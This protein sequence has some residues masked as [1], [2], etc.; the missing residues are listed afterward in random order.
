M[1][2]TGCMR[3]KHGVT[4]AEIEAVVRDAGRPR[5]EGDGKYKVV[6]RGDGGRWIQVIF[7]FDPEPEDTIYA[8]HARPLIDREKKRERRRKR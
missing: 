4:V 1:T 3:P 8:I 5:Y 6:G 2:G 7:F